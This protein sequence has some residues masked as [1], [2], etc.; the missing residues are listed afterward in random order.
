MGLLETFQSDLS[1]NEA[2]RVLI[3]GGG[4]AGLAALGAIAREE[5]VQCLLVE[6]ADQF[7]GVWDQTRYPG[8]AT[9]IKSFVYRFYNFHA[10]RS[11][12]AYASREEILAYFEE[13]VV[14][15]GLASR[16]VCG[17]SVDG[18]L[19]RRE[20]G[21]RVCTEVRSH[22]AEGQTLLLKV[23]RV[24][25]ALGFS[26]AGAPHV[27]NLPGKSLYRGK[28][29]HASRFCEEGLESVVR[30]KDRVCLVGG[31]KS[32]Y[33]VG[34]ELLRKG[35][36]SR[37]V[38]VCRKHMWGLNHEYVY[39]DDPNLFEAIRLS[40]EYFY[41]LRRAPDDT[42][43]VR[44]G[45]R[46]KESRL[47]LNLDRDEPLHQFR[48]A[49]FREQELELLREGW[50]RRRGEIRALN[51][52]GVTL[53]SGEQIQS[54]WVL[55]ATGY[56]RSGNLIPIR[57]VEDGAEAKEID[58]RE[59]GLLYRGMVNPRIP[60]ILFF[61][62]EQTFPHQ[63]Y[64][65]SFCSNWVRMYVLGDARFSLTPVEMRERLEQDEAALNGGVDDR[66]V[67][68]WLPGADQNLSGGAG[69]S[70]I[71]AAAYYQKQILD[72]LGVSSRVQSRLN[73]AQYDRPAFERANADVRKIMDS[74]LGDDR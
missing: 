41:R 66:Y 61:T 10:P 50:P 44:L 48:G 24:I 18:I 65:F 42:E 43:T 62:G 54:E 26:S 60:E 39:S 34:L 15:N 73:F 58:L 57:V 21:K 32:A 28:I 35:A 72:D 36:A 67:Y 63:L 6:R 14:S 17:V 33:D 5:G 68:R 2:E 1:V 22:N 3:I 64:G 70:S 49:H 31:G 74:S 25:C 56:R 40:G 59:H 69:F 71:E 13:Y 4:A 30:R 55:F 11:R 51:S 16:I 45:R 47:L 8:L 12:T 37:S 20:N 23:H 53:D 27:P 52:A 29:I 19:V 38:W 46:L 7:G 9:H